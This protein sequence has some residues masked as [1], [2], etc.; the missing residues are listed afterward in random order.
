MDSPKRLFRYS[1]DGRV[2]GVCA[3]I[4]KYL[5]T[6]VT[7]VRL[8]WIVLSIVPGGIVGGLLAYIAAWIIVPD[9]TDPIAPSQARRLNRS[10]TD[11][12]IAGVC[13]GFAGYFGLD[14]TVVRVAWAFLTFVPGGIV[15]G[16]VAY[17]VAWFIMPS[18]AVPP[19]AAAVP[20]A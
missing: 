11:R 8:A 9:S 20:V 1:A 15:L 2:A 5:D 10:V 14:A 16:V 6:D 17:L 4:A 13:G 3:G 19:V 18:E 12:K 7:L